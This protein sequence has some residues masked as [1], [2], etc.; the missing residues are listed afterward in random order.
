MLLCVKAYSWQGGGNLKPL[1]VSSRQVL[2]YI[3]PRKVWLA[4]NQTLPLQLIRQVIDGMPSVDIY[5]YASIITQTEKKTNAMSRIFSSI[6]NNIT[7]RMF[8]QLKATAC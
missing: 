4:S 1:T 5:Y 7:K 8:S 6:E 2:L 3:Y